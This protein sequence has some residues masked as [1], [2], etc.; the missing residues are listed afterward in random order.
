MDYLLS[1]PV[2]GILISIACY[3][4]GVKVRKLLPSPLTNPLVIA[5]ALVILVIALTPLTLEQYMVGGNMITM[6]IVPVTV[7]LALRIYRQRAL[8]RANALPILAGCVVG[9]AAS[10]FSVLW[11][12]RVFSIDKAI[13]VSMLPKS[14]TTAIA[15]ELAQKNGG[16][17]G[18]AA[19][20]VIITGVFSAAFS[21]FFVKLFRLKDPVA[22]GVAFGAS[23]HAIGTASALELGETQ[24][25]MAGVSIS[26]MG[27]ITSLIFILLFAGPW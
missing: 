3:A 19:T 1:L 9:S 7:I 16:I 6:F 11:L 13:T 24:G 12:C 18:I 17:Q 4:I 26:L 2:C 10:V 15:L 21:P 22:A 5:N 25:A 23:G 8:F 14:V 27:I 20:A